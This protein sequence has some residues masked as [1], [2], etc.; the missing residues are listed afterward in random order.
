VGRYE[1]PL[2][3]SAL[4]NFVLEHLALPDWP[5]SLAATRRIAPE[6]LILLP[7]QLSSAS[8]AQH[9]PTT[10][11]LNRTNLIPLTTGFRSA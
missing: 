1:L 5:L 9:V 10:F 7:P 6:D 3:V 4:R 8:Q 11:F 2:L